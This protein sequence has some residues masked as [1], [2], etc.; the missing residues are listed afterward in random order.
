M[1]KKSRSVIDSAALGIIRIIAPVCIFLHKPLFGWLDILLARRRNKQLTA[2]IEIS[3]SYLFSLYPGR[4]LLNEG[5]QLPLAF[6][7]ATVTV[8][9]SEIRF[10]ITRGRGELRVEVAPLHDPEDWQDL[11][12]LWCALAAPEWTRRPS[13]YDTLDETALCLQEHWRL[14]VAAMSTSQNYSTTAEKLR[15]LSDLSIE[16]QMKL[17]KMNEGLSL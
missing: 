13:P 17:R 2:E 10:R 1:V 9:F 7:F 8:Q 4:V 16:E 3:F 11:E 15:K 5:E 14:L 12:A 6:D